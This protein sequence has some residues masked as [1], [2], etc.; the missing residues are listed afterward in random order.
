MV[1]CED[2][3]Q[4]M[5]TAISCT[6]MELKYDRIYNRIPYFNDQVDERKRNKHRCHDCGVLFGR[7]HHLGCDMER[8]PKCE[9]QLISCSCD[10]GPEGV[11]RFM[12]TE[13]GNII[14]RD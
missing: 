10:E 7:I 9:G 12:I 8:C 4:D 5:K 3:N 13:T 1:K 6:V 11:Q 14:S 2:C